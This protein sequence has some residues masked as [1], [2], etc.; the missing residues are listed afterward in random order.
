[1]RFI[2]RLARS[3]PFFYGWVVIGVAFVSMALAVNARTSFSLVFPPILDEF[4]WERADTAGE[5][6]QD[7]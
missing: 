4:G 2:P 6:I 3:L 7:G 1:M 5:L